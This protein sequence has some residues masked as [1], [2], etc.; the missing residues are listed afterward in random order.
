VTHEDIKFYKFPILILTIA[1]TGAAADPALVITSPADYQVF[2]RQTKALGKVLVSGRVPVDCDRVEVHLRGDWTAL[3]LDRSTHTFRAEL[4]APSGGFYDLAVRAYS[5]GRVAAEAA[6]AHVGVGEVFVI[7][8]QSNATNYGEEKQQT[9]SGMVAAFT[10]DGW[11]LAD[12]PQ[13]GVQDTSRNG[14]FI[15]PFG[16]A[17]YE[18]L[19][20][21]IGVACVGHG[22]TSVRQWLPQGERMRVQPTMT[23]FVIPVGSSLWESTGQLFEGMMRRIRQLGPN[24]FR[25]LLWHQG[26]SDAHQ[27]PEHEITAGEYARMLREVIEAS[28]RE[29]GWDFPWFVAQASY[30]TPEDPSCPPIREAQRSLWQA[31]IALEGPDTDQLT[32]DNRQNQGRGVHMSDKGLK[33]HG[34]LW[35]DRVGA[36]L[37]GVVR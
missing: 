10:G 26:E 7:A 18:K 29:A 15:P 2:Q 27:T 12:D 28:R 32:G 4:S 17:L 37:E 6:V 9:K 5:A 14:S 24:G 19:R 13:P 8:G 25:A 34:K 22:S 16:D 35:A 20:V 21:P 1:L 23:R 11:R 3:P 33:A 30:H 36:W 31:G